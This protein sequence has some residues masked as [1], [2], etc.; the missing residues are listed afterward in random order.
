MRDRIAER[1]RNYRSS[2][3]DET[4][5]LARRFDAVDLGSGTPDMPVPAS[6]AQAVSDAIAAGRNQ[7]SP[8]A[9]TLAL[10]Q[11]VAAHGARFYD[12]RI[13]PGTEITVTNGVTEGVYAALESFVDPGDEVVLFEPC[14]DSYIP[15]VQL[16]G[17][18]VVPVAL[19]APDFR[20]D[21][22]ALLAAFSPRTKAVLL[23]NPHNPTGKVFSKTELEEI[24]ALCRRFDILV[25]A[26][27]VY[28]HVVFDGRRHV[29]F[30][31]LP[32]MAERTLT[33]SGAGKTFSC[34]GW[35][36]GWAI[37][38]HRLQ[39]ALERFRQYSVYCAPTPLQDGIAAGLSL[40]DA[41]FADLAAEYQAR[42][43][44]LMTALADTPFHVFRPDGA[45]F[46]LA[47][48]ATSDYRNGGECCR[49][50]ARDVGVVP[51]PLDT[52]FA[53]MGRAQ[54][55]VRFTYCVRR[56]VLAAA[57][58]RLARMGGRSAAALSSVTLPS[59]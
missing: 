25:I 19:S 3:F 46:V 18:I 52:F 56:E 9:G 59:C 7:Y 27:E 14:Y 4:S 8:V 11:A 16:A 41:Y 1:L 13:D 12:Q 51:V 50:L 32:G 44:I 55:L 57:S 34:T 20:L 35:R 53:S 40:P 38:P 21:S 37:G 43:D 23:N 47:S 54:D 10:R 26:D 30:A 15:S 22:A 49:V 58:E 24:A 33:L 36:I 48:F 5:A 29:R 17:G 28:E 2:V 45:F 31:T 42:R 39:Q 6:V